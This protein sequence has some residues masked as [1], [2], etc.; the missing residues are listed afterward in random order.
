MPVDIKDAA[1]LNDIVNA[2]EAISTFTL[3]RTEND[4]NHDLLLRSAVERQL[5]IIGEAARV[6][7][8]GFKD[9]NPEIP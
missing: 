4:Y 1:R 3:G 5:E 6:I 7:S 2:A 8:T 9:A